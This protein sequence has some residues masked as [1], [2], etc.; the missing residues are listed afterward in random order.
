MQITSIYSGK[1]KFLS[2]SDESIES[3]VYLQDCS[4]KKDQTTTSPIPLRQ[5]ITE[6]SRPKPQPECP[7]PRMCC[8]LTCGNECETQQSFVSRQMAPLQQNIQPLHTGKSQPQMPVQPPIIQKGRTKKS[9]SMKVLPIDG[10]RNFGFTKEKIKSLI[11]QDDDIR[12][13]L[14][15]L[16]RVTMQKVDV[17]E[18]INGKKNVVT[19][20]NALLNSEEDYE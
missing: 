11:S 5:V 18:M 7:F 20:D 19:T 15:D 4:H 13:I 2:S 8:A 14:K 10:R 6:P 3:F 12:K 17:M 16:V 1:I 9:K